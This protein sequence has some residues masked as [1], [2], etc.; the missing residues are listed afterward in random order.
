MNLTQ[1]ERIAL[2]TTQAKHATA[3]RGKQRFEQQEKQL[4]EIALSLHTDIEKRLKLKTGSL[5]TTHF[6]DY[7]TGEIIE[8]TKSHAPS[9]MERSI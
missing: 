9:L 8:R 2:F 5:G 3:V 6:V 4:A 7:S 1:A